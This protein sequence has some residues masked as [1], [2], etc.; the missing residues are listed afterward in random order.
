MKLS[1][2]I[3]V[4]NAEKHLDECL[5]SIFNE[6]DESIEVILINDGSFDNSS[7]IYGKYNFKNLKVFE[8]RNHGVSYSRN[9]GI[10]NSCG[11]WIMFVDADDILCKGWKKIILNN[12]SKD[13]D[14]IYFGNNFDT[15]KM[16]N[17]SK[18]DLIKKI[19]GMEDYNSYLSTPWSK[20]FK[21][22]KIKT[23]KFDTNVINGEDMLYNIHALE[24]S[25]KFKFINE[26]IYCYRFNVNSISHKYNSKLLNSDIRF[27]TLLRDT[28][29][30]NDID[31]DSVNKICEF[32]LYNAYLTLLNNFSELKLS[33][34]REKIK[35]FK[36]E[37]YCELIIN[38]NG[39]KSLMIKQIKK[40]KYIIPFLFFKIKNKLKKQT[41]KD[42][43]IKI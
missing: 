1:I 9:F 10:D 38:Q 30:K 33:S 34:Y 13:N 12:L 5:K 8:N 29:L 36:N 43:I 7:L 17:I 32:C 20:V 18:I 22:E 16:N 24:N 23:L 3:P 14:I 40:G 27:H 41:K 19:L 42:S 31:E 15:K 4:Y 35:C 21:R 2:I 39:I 26:S 28:L 6:Y 25:K 37:P 11:E